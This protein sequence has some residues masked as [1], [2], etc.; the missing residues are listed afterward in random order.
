MSE[1]EYFN[2]LRFIRGRNVGLNLFFKTLNKESFF[3]NFLQKKK[4]LSSY[5]SKVFIIIIFF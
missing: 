2:T 5:F 4:M 1:I 3:L